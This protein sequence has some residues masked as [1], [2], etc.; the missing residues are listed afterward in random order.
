MIS[1]LY[2]DDET[3]LLELGKQYLE[4][5]DD[6]HVTTVTSAQGALHQ[7]KTA[8]YD[9]VVSDYQMPGMDG[10]ELLKAIRSSNNAIP[11]IL[12]TGKGREEV[13]IEA[14]NSGA[15]FYL[16]KGGDP[17]SMYAELSHKIRQAVLKRAAER[18]Y[19]DVFENATEGIYQSTPGGQYIKVNPAFARISG[20]DSP[21]NLIQSITNN[22]YQHYATPSDRDTLIRVLEEKGRINHYETEFIKKDGSRIW[23]SINCHVVRD[24]NG[25]VQYYEGTMVDITERKRAQIALIGSESQFKAIFDMAGVI[26]AITDTKGMWLQCNKAF[27]ASLGYRCEELQMKNI[28]EILHPDEGNSI[29]GI[30]AGLVDGTIS[31]YR[32]EHRVIAKAGNVVWID[33]S[34]TPLRDTTGNI[35]AFTFAGT[36][37]TEYKRQEEMHINSQIQYR[38]LVDTLTSGVAV[39]EVRNDGTCGKDYIIK[40]FNKMALEIEGRTKEEVIGTSIAD[41]RPEIDDYGLIPV[42]QNVWKTGIPTYFPVKLY[43]NG[44]YANYFENRI[45]RLPTGN[46]V[47]VY[48]DITEQK[49]TEAELHESKTRFELVAANAGEWIWEVDR[50]G[51]YRYSSLAVKNILGY[52]P[53]ELIGKKHFYDLF[54]PQQREILKA[55]GLSMFQCQRSFQ[56]FVNTN[57]CKDGS[58]VILETSG[59]PIIDRDGNLVGYRGVDLDIT[60]RVKADQMRHE[61][62]KQLKDKLD[63]IL[64]PECAIGEDDFKKIIDSREIQVLM[65]DLYSI[66]HIGIAILDLKG[67]ILVATGWQDIC[68]KFHR[69]NEQSCKNCRE[70]DLHFTKNV[71]PGDYLVYKC[72][73]NLWDM[74]TPITIGKKHMGNLFLGQIFFDDEIPDYAA[75]DEQAEKFGFDKEE[76]RAAL[77]RVPRWN[78]KNIST[79][80]DFYSRFASM[81]ARLSYSNISLAKQLLDQKRSEE[82]LQASEMRYKTLIE[83]LPARIFLKDTDST[84]ISCNPRFAQDIGIEADDIAGKNDFDF[85]SPMF[86]EKY[87]ADDRQI[88]ATQEDKVF[89]EKYPLKDQDIWV[90]TTK[91]PVKN[92][93]G[94]ISGILGIFW[95]IDDRIKT[96][97]QLKQASAQK[98]ALIS[99]IP[100]PI[101]IVSEDGKVLDYHALN[102]DALIEKTGQISGKFL[103]EVFPSSFAQDALC[104]IRCAATTKKIQCYEY[105]LENNGLRFFESRIAPCGNDEFIMIV[106]DITERKQAENA[107]F[108][109]NKKIVLVNSITHHD[110]N[111][112]LTILR[113]RLRLLKKKSCDPVLQSGIE[114]IE[115]AAKIIC[116]QLENAHLYQRIGSHLPRWQNIGTLVTNTEQQIAHTDIAITVSTGTLEIYA[117]PLFENVI[118]NLIDNALRHGNR[119]SQFDISCRAHGDSIVISCMDNGRG[120]PLDQKERIFERG[121]G[122][123]TGMGLFLAREILAITKI[124]IEETGIPGQGARFDI[125]VPSGAYRYSES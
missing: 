95:D 68:T 125:H 24:R 4:Q 55:G 16:Q 113:G 22:K 106:R 88:I 85:Y 93:H 64:S 32:S 81:I 94:E 23:I 39:Y 61:H 51:V 99:A 72:K 26:I 122:A 83:H 114:D 1:I 40:D 46:I 91:T 29:L 67:N 42:M 56:K 103:H 48:N 41:L 120:V 8:A 60:A 6:L 15:D 108:A 28:C 31:S 3:D 43:A 47:A 82:K 117:D 101:F 17:H 123:N 20:Y 7:V 119:V 100:D 37:I 53:E 25:V 92:E 118:A 49:R 65:E 62:E 115:K 107:L 50:Q 77:D 104:A 58:T 2:V 79:V 10:I 36:D 112:Q 21:E 9:A 35:V 109:A 71:K 19:L 111:N 75:F 5:S 74:V 66:A 86:A 34:V 54:V 121:V 57:V 97:Q 33:I 69:V 78:R 14:I 13:V 70:S 12:F 80:M 110:V 30:R 102:A 89:F 76:Y 96:E 90:Q 38:E 63:A 59:T 45:F 44:K 52:T 87:R 116:N 124:T 73:N 84:Y 11:F 98:N 18:K 105:S 27:S